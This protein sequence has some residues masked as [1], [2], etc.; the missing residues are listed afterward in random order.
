MA[1][2]EGKVQTDSFWV[3]IYNLGGALPPAEQQK[4]LNDLT[5]VLEVLPSPRANKVIIAHS[6]PQGVGL[7]G[8]SDLGT[9]IVKPNGQG[10]GFEVVGRFTLDEWL[11]LL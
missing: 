7:G 3:R 11:S 6:F 2:G 9:V 4:T 10:K 1:F 8:I 5:S